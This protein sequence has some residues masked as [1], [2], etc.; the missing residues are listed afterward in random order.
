MKRPQYIRYESTTPKLEKVAKVIRRVMPDFETINDTLFENIKRALII[1]KAGVD[2]GNDEYLLLADKLEKCVPEKPCKSMACSLCQRNRRLK[3]MNKWTEYFRQNQEAY[4]VVTL[5]FYADKVQ[6]SAMLDWD[7]IKLRRRLVKVIQRIGFN[8]PVIGGF[9]M[10]YHNYTHNPK[11]SH[12]MPHFHLLMPNEPEKLEQLRKYMLREKNLRAREGRRN[13]PMRF[14]AFQDVERQMSYCISGI[15]MEYSWF[16]DE[17]GNL[18]KSTYP[19]RIND[20]DMY[21]K[22][23]VMLDG[24]SEGALTFKVNVQDW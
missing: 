1:H 8:A 2:Q 17:E 20:E 12:W 19:R 18:M 9:E 3:F 15:W 16:L 22:S 14:D 4:V 23:L 11:A 5:I 7:L 21:A 6:G 24:L 13:R 10:D